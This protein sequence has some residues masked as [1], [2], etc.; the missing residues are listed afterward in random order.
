MVVDTRFEVSEE[1]DPH[2]AAGVVLNV[3]DQ[4]NHLL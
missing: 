1:A 3:S 4:P 2:A